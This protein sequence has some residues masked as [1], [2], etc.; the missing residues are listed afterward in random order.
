LSGAARDLLQML[1]NIGATIKPAGDH[2]ILRA[3]DVPVPADVVARVR[4]AKADLL[5]LLTAPE[6]GFELP[7]FARRGRIV[8]GADELFLHFCCECGAWAPFGY[9]VK[10]RE[11]R[12]GRW[13]C[14]EHKPRA[15]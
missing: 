2:L 8:Q 14:A 5:A 12:A 11:G 15:G 6:P 7:C 1:T 10:L 13:Y 9:G 3:G 4:A